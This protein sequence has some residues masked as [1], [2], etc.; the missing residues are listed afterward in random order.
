MADQALMEVVRS[1]S[2]TLVA[3]LAPREAGQFDLWWRGCLAAIERPIEAGSTTS[4]IQ[5]LQQALPFTGSDERVWTVLIIMI[6]YFVTQDAVSTAVP[7]KRPSEQSINDAIISCAEALKAPP[8][9]RAE[10][11]KRFGP[12]LHTALDAGVTGDTS[13]AV[14]RSLMA[15][16]TVLRPEHMWRVDWCDTF[17]PPGAKVQVH[18]D[19]FTTCE[20]ATARFKDLHDQFV[21][22]VDD[23][24]P[25]IHIR[26][27]ARDSAS[28]QLRPG[29]ELTLPVNKL[30]FR[31]RQLLAA[32]LTSFGKPA[33]ILHWHEVG[34]LWGDPKGDLGNAISKAKGEL[35]Q[36]LGK[37]LLE[38]VRAVPGGQRYE[39]DG[40]F[41]YCW[42]R[43]GQGSQ[44]LG[45]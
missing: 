41:P 19:Q 15:Q 6:V 11:V 37:D 20:E 31:L 30:N 28:G 18:H 26:R 10:L 14:L 2:S 42:I 29:K 34:D 16:G 4:P 13:A 7:L 1:F 38:N 22:F 5:R 24:D 8:S 43:P 9:L 32:I 21:L 12:V 44:R 23:S 33:R 25:S 27:P 17:Y 39:I 45:G 35:D 3:E 40:Q 36:L